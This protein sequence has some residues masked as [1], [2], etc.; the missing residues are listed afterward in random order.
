[1]LEKPGD[2]FATDFGAVIEYAIDNCRNEEDPRQAFGMPPEPY[3]LDYTQEYSR[4]ALIEHAQKTIAPGLAGWQRLYREI[5][6]DQSKF[7]LLTVVAYRAIGWRYV[8]MPLDN[9][10][11]RACLGE[12]AKSIDNVVTLSLDG[13]SLQRVDLRRLGFDAKLLSDPFGVFNEFVYSQY[14]YR[15]TQEYFGPRRGDT[16]IDC[17]ACFGGTSLFFASCVGP[18]GAVYSFEFMDDNVDVFSLNMGLNPALRNRIDLV[19]AP[20]WSRSGEAM[21]VSGRGPSAQVDSAGNSRRPEG[22]VCFH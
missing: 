15:G 14:V 13:L 2:D 5:S 16:V 7:L 18:E 10:K 22:I 8:K 6:D 1:M 17:G 20:V 3:R 4:S 11:F 12:I 19:K 9:A 21:Y